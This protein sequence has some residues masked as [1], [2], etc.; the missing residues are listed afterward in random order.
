MLRKYA[1]YDMPFRVYDSTG[2]RI[3]PAQRIAFSGYPGSLVSG[4]DFNTMSTGLVSQETTI[5]CSNATLSKQ[6]V[7][8]ATVLEWVRVMVAN[9][10]A[11]SGEEWTTLF[12][13]HNSGTYNNQ[14]MV[15]DY[16]RFSPGSPP[17]AGALW[18]IE[19]IPT[20]TEAHD[21][22]PAL[23]SQGYWAS[24]NI[25]A[26][27]R[28]FNMSGMWASVAKYGDWFTHDK[29]PR[30]RIFAR[31][32][33]KVHDMDS[34]AALMRYNDF[35]HDPLSACDCKPQP[36]S[37]ENAIAC[38]DDLNPPGTY[39][40]PALGP[41]NHAATDA[42][43]T[44]HALMMGAGG[45]GGGGVADGGIPM[46]ARAVSSPTYDQQP[47]F[48]WSASPY[49]NVTHLGQPDRFDFK[50]EDMDWQWLAA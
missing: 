32:Q 8:P 13:R 40:I 3:V 21:Q 25:A 17:A 12:A 34:M 45:A 23:L 11:T 29:N 30:A 33:G 28:V 19:Q 43:I 14:W 6:G 39:P 24:Y 5:G 20:Y 35:Q 42:K 36:Y 46:A 44:S 16:K 4:D 10:L 22:T 7:V 50:F 48:V 1:A 26:Y 37:A 49:A 2:S 9:R 47:V 27:P 38:R 18:V 15:T 31:D 41:R